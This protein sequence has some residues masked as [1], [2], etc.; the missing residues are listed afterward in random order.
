MWFVDKT[1]KQKNISKNLVIDFAIN[2]KKEKNTT[3]VLNNFWENGL[4]LKNSKQ[5]KQTRQIKQ[6]KYAKYAKT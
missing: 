1:K 5:I 6:T 2:E 4:N 3:I